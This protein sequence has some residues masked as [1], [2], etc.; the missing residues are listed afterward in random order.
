MLILSWTMVSSFLHVRGGVSRREELASKREEFSPRAWRCFLSPLFARYRKGVF[1]TCVEVFLDVKSL[2]L[3]V[4]SF[5]HVRG[6]VSSELIREFMQSGF[7]PRAWRCFPPIVYWFW[8]R[9]VF[10]TCVEVFL[11]MF[12]RFMVRLGFLH[13]RGGVSVA[14]ITM[15]FSQMF[16][17][18]AWR[19][20]GSQNPPISVVLVFSTCVEVFL[21][22]AFRELSNNSFLH[23]RGGVS[24]SSTRFTGNAEFSPRAWR[25]F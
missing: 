9:C 21:E 11:Q 3:D 15:R 10:S 23:V 20:F 25:C 16:S 22:I 6:G 24:P 19:C 17:P 4:T 8:C 14:P 5:L 13:V 2:L 1:S 12:S 18:R 7:S